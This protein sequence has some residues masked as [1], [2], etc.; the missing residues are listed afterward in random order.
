MGGRRGER[1]REGRGRG[2][3]EGVR[4]KRGRREKEVDRGKEEGRERDRGGK[5]G[6]K[7]GGAFESEIPLKLRWR[8][9]KEEEEWK[10]CKT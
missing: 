2:G 6:K 1:G 3:G 5:A 7:I 10:L 4:E 8:K 9:T